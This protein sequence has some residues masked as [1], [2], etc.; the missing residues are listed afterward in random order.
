MDTPMTRRLLLILVLLTASGAQTSADAPSILISGG[1]VIDGTGSPGRLAD[2]RIVAGRIRE[3]GKLARRAGEQVIDA[4]GMVVAPGFID[5]HSHAD[6]GALNLPGAA[7]NVRQGITTVVVGQ[8]GQSHFPLAGWFRSLTS[9]GTAINVASFAGHGTVRARVMGASYKRPA[10]PEEIA[11]MQALVAQEMNSG[12]LGLSS[13]LEYD[14]GYYASTSELVSLAKAASAGG[15]YISHVRDEGDGALTSFRELIRIAL[16]GR[17]PA[18]IS[19]IKLDTSPVWHKAKEALG[20][21]ARARSAKLDITADVYPY[22]YWQS[23]I[24]VLT[25]DRNWDNRD[26]WVKALLEMGGPQHVLL[27]TYTPDKTWVGKTIAQIASETGKDAVAVIQQIVHSTHDPGRMGLE[28]VVVTAM[29]EEDLDAFLKDPHIMFCT[30]GQPSGGHPRKAGSFP[31]I[32]GRYVREQHLLT[33]PEAIRK[34]TSLPA[35]RFGFAGRGLIR[36]GM[37]ADVVVFDPRTV[38][39]TSTTK[40][41]ASPPV[42]IH[43]VLVNGEPVLLNDKPTGARP[44]SVLPRLTSVGHP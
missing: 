17:L 22:L 11:K 24:T 27:T 2:V 14:P 37:W 8:D 31:R 5:A 38:V 13:G 23:T 42:G 10:R 29:T 12:A 44:G 7:L 41:P 30:D 39:D 18:Q 9:V 26:V 25:L 15:M 33:L 19:H 3:V 4:H 28:S 32:L 16:E 20:L 36:S 34:A 35:Q 21:M 40:S 6:E 1:T 43:D